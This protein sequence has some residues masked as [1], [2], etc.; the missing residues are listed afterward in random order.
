[1]LIKEISIIL[2]VSLMFHPI[3]C[4]VYWRSVWILNN[5]SVIEIQ[6]HLESKLYNLWCSWIYYLSEINNPKKIYIN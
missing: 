1:M 2:L 5:E 3:I 6:I 4:E